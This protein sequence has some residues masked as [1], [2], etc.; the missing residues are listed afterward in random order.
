MELRKRRRSSAS[1]RHASD[2]VT[3]LPPQQNAQREGGL[4][5]Q[6]LQVEG[7]LEALTTVSG[8][9]QPVPAV[10]GQRQVHVSPDGF[11]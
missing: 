11:A 2:F 3:S 7:A 9:G 10:R 6:L 1:Q 8:W 4:R 5:P